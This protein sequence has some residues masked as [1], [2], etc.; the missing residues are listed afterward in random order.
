MGLLPSVMVPAML[1]VAFEN[2]MV[3]V[4]ELFP[5]FTSTRCS[6]VLGSPGLEAPTVYSPSATLSAAVP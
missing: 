5:A 6:A 2:L 1:A 3:N 4:G